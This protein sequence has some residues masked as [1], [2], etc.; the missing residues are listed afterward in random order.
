MTIL[1]KS[2]AYIAT[3][4]L[5]DKIEYHPAQSKT[6]PSI[7]MRINIKGKQLIFD[8][9]VDDSNKVID[10]TQR[11]YH[12]SVTQEPAVNLEG[13]DYSDI[14]ASIVKGYF[15]YNKLTFRTVVMK[16]GSSALV[17]IADDKANARVIK[18]SKTKSDNTSLISAIK[19]LEKCAKSEEQNRTALKDIMTGRVKTK[20]GNASLISSIAYLGSCAKSREHNSTVLKD[21]MTSRVKEGDLFG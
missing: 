12:Q 6:D 2:Y 11:D 10:V 15:S 3:L 8:L 5:S 9:K 7:E 16:D 21:I 14:D 17:P 13:N 1:F 4:T 18:D 19:F 20:S